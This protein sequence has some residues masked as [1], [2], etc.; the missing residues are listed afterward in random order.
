MESII[1]DKLM[2]FIDERDLLSDDQHGFRSSRSSV[3]QL[4]EIAEIWSSMLDE[5]GGMDVVYLDF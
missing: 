5:G 4:L 3:T 1:T 2:E